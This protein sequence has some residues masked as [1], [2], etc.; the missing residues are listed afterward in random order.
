M[1]LEILNKIFTVF[2]PNFRRISIAQEFQ[3]R[4]CYCLILIVFA[5]SGSSLYSNGLI[6]CDGSADFQKMW[7][8]IYVGQKK[9]YIR[10]NSQQSMGKKMI[11]KPWYPNHLI[12]PSTIERGTAR[13]E[14]NMRKLK[15][16][17]HKNP[18]SKFI[19]HVKWSSTQ[20]LNWPYCMEFHTLFFAYWVETTYME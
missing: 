10:P 13:W 1:D 2:L 18:K 17:K 4:S 9:L 6:H 12:Q 19:G 20:F 5:M 15:K 8:I 14:K 7:K 11:P 16:M 3:M